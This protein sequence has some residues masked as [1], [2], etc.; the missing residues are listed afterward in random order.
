MIIGTSE[1]YRTVREWRFR[2]LRPRFGLAGD[3]RYFSPNTTGLILV[4]VHVDP[5]YR[6]MSVQAIPERLVRDFFAMN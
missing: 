3:P 1:W 2:E 5:I 4:R 6:R